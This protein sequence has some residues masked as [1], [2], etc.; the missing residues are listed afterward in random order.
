MELP[1][2]RPMVCHGRRAS[3]RWAPLPGLGNARFHPLAQ[4]LALKFCK[5]RQQ[6]RQRASGRRGEIQG[7]AQRDKPNPEG[8]QLVQG[9]DEVGQGPAPAI[10]AP[11]DNGIDVA[12]SRRLHQG[13]ALP[14]LT[15]SRADLLDED[16]DLPGALLH[17]RFHGL[18]L[19]RQRLLILRGHSGIEPDPPL[20][21]SWPKTLRED[22]R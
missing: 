3:M 21:V 16:R 15:A 14:A 4:A 22:V 7:F 17:V 19:Q 6:P 12:A 9:P 11:D 20:V 10:Q 8:M 5:D 1:R 13:L 18:A 2:R